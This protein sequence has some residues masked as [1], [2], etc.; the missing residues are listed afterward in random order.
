M[1]DT[2]IYK[3]SS[4]SIAMLH[5]GYLLRALFA[6][7]LLPFGFS[8]FHLPGLSVLG[9][10][11][12][13]AQ[14]QE[15]PLKESVVIGFV[16]GLGFFGFGISWIYVSIHDYG[17][18][19]PL[20]SFLATSL[21]VS[22][23]SLYPALVAMCYQPL[24]SKKGLLSNCFL[25]GA[26]WCLGEYLRSNV[27]S[28]CPWLQLGFGQIDSPLKYMLPIVGVYG[29]SFLTCLSATLLV[30]STQTVALQRCLYLFAF[31]GI[32]LA[33]LLL[34]DTT[35][36]TLN[37]KPISVGVVQANLS[38][39]DKWDES[40]FWKLLGQYKTAIKQLIGK[41]N[42]I[43]LPESAIPL[44][45]TY[46]SHYINQIDA[47][48]KLEHTSV[49]LG[50]PQSTPHD[51][52][53][54]FNTLT[55]LGMA[56]GHYLKQHLVPFGEYIPNPF[57]SLTRWLDIP[58]ATLKPGPAHQALVQVDNHLIATLICYE[59]AYPDLLRHQLPDAEWIVS[60]SD[61]GWFGRSLAVYQQLQMSQVLSLLTGRYQI[62]SNNDGLSSI[63]DTQGNITSTLPAFTAG[64]L[65]GVIYPATEATPWTSQG[66]APILLSCILLILFSLPR[67]IKQNL[68]N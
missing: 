45:A 56:D 39:R 18:L 44:P 14:L 4:I 58:L 16:F 5:Y 67:R 1:T 46:I 7:I 62:V 24:A 11:L 57:L 20:L 12:L 53:Y 35:W 32:L 28:G 29:T 54:Y 55:A 47:H 49:L 59:V 37:N 50:I 17:H 42:V 38:M 41:K 36:V 15:R 34:Q 21:F 51:N 13:F 10:A 23:L 66:D 63:I 19:N 40:L 2:Q 48:A 31:V 9:I 30:K 65:D 26:L 27:L 33:P 61:D 43:V 68:R 60:I 64:I 6:G 3:A 22:Y 25:F 52:G 8:P